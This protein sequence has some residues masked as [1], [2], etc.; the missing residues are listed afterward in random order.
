VSFIIHDAHVDILSFPTRRSSDL[1]AA[2]LD[3][4]LTYKGLGTDA[5]VANFMVKYIRK[6]GLIDNFQHLVHETMAKEPEDY[7]PAM[8]ELVRSEEH[9]SELQSRENLV[10][11]LLLEK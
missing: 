1:D 5:S 8:K 7:V 6:Y 4:T 2:D 10:C 9:T 3:N 11:R